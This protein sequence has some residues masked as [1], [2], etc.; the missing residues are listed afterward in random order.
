MRMRGKKGSQ[1]LSC[2]E[3]IASVAQVGSDF[4]SNN[5]NQ[6]IE[7]MNGKTKGKNK[8]V[9]SIKW[10]HLKKARTQQIK[11]FVSLCRR[12]STA[13]TQSSC[14]WP[15]AHNGTRH[16]GPL[17]TQSLSLHHL[18]SCGTH[19]DLVTH[20]HTS[21][22]VLRSVRIVVG[23][24]GRNLL[25]FPENRATKGENSTSLFTP[26]PFWT[27]NCLALRFFYLHP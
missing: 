7:T 20:T 16:W 5:R 18:T 3:L 27:S 15:G 17:G 24:Q 14:S 26:F 13:H 4:C 22:V 2:L 10:D 1:L 23:P 12:V 8:L 21:S 6:D 11:H 25:L 9:I 19:T